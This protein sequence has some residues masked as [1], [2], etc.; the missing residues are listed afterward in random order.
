MAEKPFAEYVER[1]AAPILEI[2]QREFRDSSNV[3]EI[4]SGTG[5]HAVMFAKVFDIFTGRQAIWM[6]ITRA[7][8]LGRNTQNLKI[9]VHL[10]LW[11]FAQQVSTKMPTMQLSHQI[12]HI[13]WASTPLKGCSNCLG[14]RCAK[15]EYSAC[16]VRCS[17]V[18]SS[19]RKAMQI[20]TQVC[21]SETPSWGYET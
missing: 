20:L 19:T 9:W 7:Y 5:Q 2:L 18:A 6:K 10:C 11:T 21:G 14:K 17:V 15:G 4:G 3:L 8:A 1:N 13:S 16:T 12:P